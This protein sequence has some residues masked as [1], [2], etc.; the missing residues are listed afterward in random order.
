VEVVAP[1]EAEIVLALKRCT[2]AGLST[3]D[4]ATAVAAVLQRPRR[5]VYALATRSPEVVGTGEDD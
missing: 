5:E 1:G 2:E 3:R 4:A